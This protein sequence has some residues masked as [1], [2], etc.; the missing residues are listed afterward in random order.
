M[1]LTKLQMHTLHPFIAKPTIELP[2]RN[3]KAAWRV[4]AVVLKNPQHFPQMT[5]KQVHII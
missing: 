1:G 3:A 2:D 4:N 5:S